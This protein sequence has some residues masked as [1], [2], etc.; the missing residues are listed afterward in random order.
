MP[1]F[2]AV[3]QCEK[4]ELRISSYLAPDLG[5]PWWSTYRY[6]LEVFVNKV[7]GR[8]PHAWITKEDSIESA[9]VI[10]S[11]Y[12]KMGNVWYIQGISRVHHLTRI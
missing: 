7:S 8:T 3:I 1:G 2:G 6:Q 5:Q 4:G 11:V 10:E 9:I 12:A